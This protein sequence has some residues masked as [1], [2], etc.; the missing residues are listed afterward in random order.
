MKKV[1]REKTKDKTSRMYD[2]LCDEIEK[3]PNGAR[4]FVTV[5]YENLTGGSFGSGHAMYWEVE[6]GKVTFYD[7]QSK[8]SGRKNDVIF[9]LCEPSWT[10]YGRLDNLELKEEVTQHV[11]SRKGK[12]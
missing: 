2:A 3:Y 4:G 8:K 5:A 10:A 12:K 6:N 9:S 11:M 1:K 7:G